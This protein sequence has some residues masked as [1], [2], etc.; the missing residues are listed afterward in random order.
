[1]WVIPARCGWLTV[2]APILRCDWP[3][4]CVLSRRCLTRGIVCLVAEYWLCESGLIPPLRAERRTEAS[5]AVPRSSNAH[6]A[7]KGL[8]MIL[9]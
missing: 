7:G 8:L 4:P 6:W 1:M 2:R 5:A 9:V 3:S